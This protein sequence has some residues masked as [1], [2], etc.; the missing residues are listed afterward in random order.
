MNPGGTSSPRD[1]PSLSLAGAHFA[2]LR[3]GSRAFGA[4]SRAARQDMMKGHVF[5]DS[6]FHPH[7]G[8]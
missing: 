8:R 5:H 3:C 4:P 2:P 7:L 1:P 6:R